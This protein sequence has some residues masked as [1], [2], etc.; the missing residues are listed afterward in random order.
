MGMCCNT[1]DKVAKDGEM[2]VPGLISHQEMKGKDST[3]VSN[4]Q[5]IGLFE[6]QKLEIFKQNNN[7]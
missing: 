1:A 2:E 3:Q 6:G 7:N 5:T 4:E